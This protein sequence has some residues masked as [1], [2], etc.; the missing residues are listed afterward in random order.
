MQTKHD[1]NKKLQIPKT[2]LPHVVYTA[3]DYPGFYE[4]G[5]TRNS[6]HFVTRFG[7]AKLIC[8]PS[9]NP[10]T[11]A[12]VFPIRIFKGRKVHMKSMLFYV[13]KNDYAITVAWCTP[14]L[15]KHREGYIRINVF[16]VNTKKP[17]HGGRVVIRFDALLTH[18]T[19]IPPELDLPWIFGPDGLSKYLFDLIAKV[20]SLN[21]LTFLYDITVKAFEKTICE[22]TTYTWFKNSKLPQKFEK[23]FSS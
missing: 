20:L 11:P 21:D 22:K 6:P 10:K 13:K 3:M 12:N 2:H 5:G 19:A 17:S 9:G 23:K 15:I 7:Y 18:Y 14:N 16:K 1:D 8:S 4:E